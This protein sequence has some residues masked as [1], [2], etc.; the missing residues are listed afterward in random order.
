MNALKSWNH[1]NQDSQV[2]CK[3]CLLEGHEY[4]AKYCR[5]CGTELEK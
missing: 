2:R 5:N 1:E 4:D 3:N